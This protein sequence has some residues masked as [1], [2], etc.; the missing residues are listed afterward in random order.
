MG[1]ELLAEAGNYAAVQ[2]LQQNPY[3]SCHPVAQAIFSQLSQTS[4]RQSTNT[5]QLTPGQAGAQN[6]FPSLPMNF[7]MGP[8][9]GNMGN[10]GN[11]AGP[12]GFPPFNK[13]QQNFPIMGINNSCKGLSN[14]M[15]QSLQTN[16]H[17]AFSS[18][19][20][21]GINSNSQQNPFSGTGILPE[22]RFGGNNFQALTALKSLMFASQQTP[23]LALPT[24][25][26]L[27]ANINSNNAPLS[28]G[29]IQ[30]NSNPILALL[31]NF[32]KDSMNSFAESVKKINTPPISQND[33]NFLS[34]NGVN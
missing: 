4:P 24:I 16:S 31:N 32:H 8:S 18:A 17:D 15:E 3:W 21:E 9:V 10:N 27:I 22:N 26:S 34:E 33:S 25:L 12:N 29:N 23:N 28:N 11:S 5:G 7:P 2:M 1:L 20:L 13:L 19:N 14:E 30:N 6:G